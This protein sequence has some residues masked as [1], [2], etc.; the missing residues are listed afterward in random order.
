MVRQDSERILFPH[1]SYPIIVRFRK[2]EKE[3]YFAEF[4]FT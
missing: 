4:T 2:G 1:T 3:Q